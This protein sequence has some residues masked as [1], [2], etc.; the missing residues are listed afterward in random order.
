MK[1]TVSEIAALSG[2]RLLFGDGSALVTDFITNSKDAKAGTMF[3]P[4]HGENVDGHR[5]IP[6]ALAAGAASFTDHPI[7]PVDGPV[8][9]VEDCRAALQ[10]VG[11]A[12]RARFDIPVVGI[13]GSVGKTTAKEM[14]ALGLT[15]SRRVWRTPGN[16]NSQ[17]GVPTTVCG[18]EPEHTAAVIEM[19]VSMPGEMARIAKVTKPTCGIITNIGTSHLEFMGSRENILAEKLHMA[20][21]LPE[22]APLFVNGDNDL[23]AGVKSDRYRVVPFGLGD[24]CHW[25]A[26]SIAENPQGDGLSFTCLSPDGREQTVALPVLGEHNV[27]NALAAMALGDF[28]GQSLG[29]TARALSAYEPPAMRQQIKDAGGITVIDDTYNASPDSMESAINILA[30][31]PE[32]GRRIAVLAGMRE[33]GSYEQ[34]GHRNTGAYA[35]SKGVELLA[36]GELGG[37]MAQGYGPGAVRVKDNAE[38]AAWLLHTLKPGDS[39]LV[40]GSRGMKTEEIVNALI[41][42]KGETNAERIDKG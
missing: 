17:V 37:L 13:T 11:E 34:A 29:D 18:I 25:R 41:Q 10:K 7:D 23:L 3:V 20:D 1:M 36:V 2:G 14:A 9:L 42:S 35:R 30:S 4:I 21:Y 24:N 22:G 8:V 31:R 39:V 33:L 15:V 5:F 19:G 12:Y 40:K 32:T 27:R 38:A 6:N 28:F 16:A 26:E